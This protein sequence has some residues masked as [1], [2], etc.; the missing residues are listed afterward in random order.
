MSQ[1]LE[2]LQQYLEKMNRFNHVS[3]LLYWDMRTGAPKE[4][5]ERHADAVAYFSTEAFKM[6]TAEELGTMLD[7]LS[8]PEEYEKLDDTWKFIVKNIW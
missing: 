8:V 6:G 1:K 7:E 3:T 5:F 4:G 2:T